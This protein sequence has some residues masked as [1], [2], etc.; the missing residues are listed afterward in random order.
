MSI[1]RCLLLCSAIFLCIPAAFAQTDALLLSD[2]HFEPF[3]D[4]G[5]VAALEAAPA[6]NWAAILASPPSPDK[7]QRFAALGSSCH[8][9]GLDTSYTLFSSALHAMQAQAANARFVTVSGDLISHSF[10]CKYNTLVPHAKPGEYEAFVTKTL[11]FVVASLRTTFPDVPIYAA[12]GNND[13][14]CGDYQL[15]ARSPFL[16]A[17]GKTILQDVPESQ[18]QEALKSFALGGYYSALLPPPLNRT[19]LI[20]LNHLFMSEKYSSCGGA[21]NPAEID[22]QL[23]WARDQLT[24]ARRDHE[25]VWIMGHIPPGVNA[26]ATAAKMANICGGEPPAMFLS[27][28]RLESLLLEFDD[29]IELG[30]FGHTH[31]DELRLVKPYGKSTRG[32][33]IKMVPSISPVDGN[34]PSFTV[35]RITSGILKDYEVYAASNQTGVDTKWPLEYDYART[36]HQTAF[37]ASAVSKLTAAF[38]ADPDATTKESQDYIRYFFVGDRWA[39]LSMFWPQY[40]CALSNLSA[41]DFTSC[42]CS[43]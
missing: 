27:S 32:V 24:Q 23:G 6:A 29:V 34:N 33:A 38:L 20:V 36:Y 2:F 15:D 42:M 41:K 35:A 7:E 4:P 31:M 16:T 40:T 12:L 43:H 39:E 14:A 26:Y 9:R 3:A 10:S 37:S 21:P 1:A 17:A 5:K 19:R 25:K 22:E 11:E 28:E 18:R 13:T 30:I 8:S